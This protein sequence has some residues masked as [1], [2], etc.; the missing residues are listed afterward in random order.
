MNTIQAWNGILGSLILKHPG[1]TSQR[2][3]IFKWCGIIAWQLPCRVVEL[4]I[5]LLQ[6]SIVTQKY[7]VV[8]SSCPWVSEDGVLLEYWLK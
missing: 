7:F 8:P 1:A 2:L 3:N 4:L 6:D 5:E